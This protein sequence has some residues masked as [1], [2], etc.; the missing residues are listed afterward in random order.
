[1]LEFLRKAVKSWVAKALL[2][3]LVA[4]FAVFGIGD[5]FRGGLGSAVVEVGDQEIEAQAFAAAYN[6]EIRAMSRQFGQPIDSDSARAMGLD[7]QVLG[8]MA[9]EATLDQALFELGVSAPDD[10]VADDILNDPNFQGA[11][12]FDEERYRYLIAQAGFG[13]ERYEEETRRALARAQLSA[14]LATGAAPPGAAEL[15]HQ[16]R[17]EK[18]RVDY[19]TLNAADHTEPPEAPTDADLTAFH[20]ANAERFTAPER[21]TA[22]YLR[23]AI[24]ELAEEVEID[25][26]ELRD[27][28][29]RRS[30]EYNDPET[31]AVYQIVYDDAGEAAAAKARLASGE[32]DFDGLLAERG[33]TRADVS[34]GEVARDDLI[35]AVA[36]AAFTAEEGAVVG[37]VDTGFGAALIEVAAISPAITIPFEDAADELRADLAREAALDLSP[38][39]AGEIEDLRAGGMTLEEVANETGLTLRRAVDVPATGGEGFAGDPTFATALFAAEMDEEQDLIETPDGGY[40]VLRLEEVKP[41]ALRPLSE[42][43]ADVITAWSAAERAKALTATM[44]ALLTRA[45]DGEL[46]AALADEMGVELASE[47]PMTRGAQWTA[48]SP[49]MV[50]LMF[51]EEM[52]GALVGP[53]PARPDA[54][55]LAQVVG[56]EPA[57]TTGDAAE[58]LAAIERQLAALTGRD[59]ISLFIQAK[60][61]EAGVSINQT[62]LDSI[63]TQSGR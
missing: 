4:S 1:M 55:V 22:V 43:R 7:Q 16:W 34:L 8:R 58:E 28:Y 62:L 32:I 33:E 27:L 29:E 14:A 59:A 54:L 41:A 5:V 57:E 10:A 40:F 35:G 25:E 52:G 63:L 49:Q 26:S 44:D 38:E 60:Q 36:E 17:G 47:G 48:L 37:P 46:L 24:D 6:S 20:K 12:G 19:F 9:A 56:I 15:L 61:E 53:S 13:V 18:R 30:D 2:G 31:R 42:V 39:R 51:R 45:D 21:R 23:V 11:S 50:Q 3:I